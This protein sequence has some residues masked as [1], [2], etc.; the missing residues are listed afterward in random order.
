MKYKRICSIVLIGIILTF[1]TAC[2]KST[3]NS[4]NNLATSKEVQVQKVKNESVSN[5]SQLSGTLQPLQEVTV[6][7]EV[8]DGINSLNVQE[9][10]SVNVEDILATV[11]SK[12]YE[13]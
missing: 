8:S 11:D 5:L 9:G 3:N 1:P 6:S 10:T 4:K 13:L 7:F 2:S 12:D